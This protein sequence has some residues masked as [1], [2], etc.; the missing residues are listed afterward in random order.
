MLKEKDIVNQSSIPIMNPGIQKVIEL[1]I[2][3]E[4]TK[5]KLPIEILYT[6]CPKCSKGQSTYLEGILQLRNP[7][8]DLLEYV[9]RD[10]SKHK[11]K[12]V[13]ITKTE[14]LSNGLDLYITSKRYLRSLGNRLK[15]HFK[16]ELNIAPQLFS[17]NRQKS[18][19]IY[20]INVLFRM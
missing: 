6:I 8:S 17:R 19:D 4:K 2:V 13:F 5:L 16:G 15:K 1:D 12:G 20:R 7:S 11:A 14:K 3:K 9:H 10:I 18:K